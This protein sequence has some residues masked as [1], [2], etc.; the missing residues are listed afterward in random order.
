M[1]VGWVI[2]MS[3]PGVIAETLID[4]LKTHSITVSQVAIP[5]KDDATTRRSKSARKHQSRSEFVNDL[6]VKLNSATVVLSYITDTFCNDTAGAQLLAF[7]SEQTRKTMIPVIGGQ[8]LTVQ[9][10]Q[11]ASPR[12]ARGRRVA[13]ACS[14]VGCYTRTLGGG[15]IRT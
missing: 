5:A 1:V 3:T 11:Q 4:D 15:R 14:C 8:Y 6:G 9:S 10:H 7:I 12:R 2:E 13:W